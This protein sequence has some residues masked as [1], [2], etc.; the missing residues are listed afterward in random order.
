MTRHR[1][2]VRQA[3][4]AP[5]CMSS[6]SQDSATGTALVGRGD[7]YLIDHLCSG[8]GLPCPRVGRN[9]ARKQLFRAVPMFTEVY[10]SMNY[11][12]R[13]KRPLSKWPI[14]HE[15]SQNSRPLHPPKITH[16]RSSGMGRCGRTA[17][18]RVF[19]CFLFCFVFNC[20]DST[21]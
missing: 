16:R 21:V 18:F 1:C 10:R 2:L 13:E 15:T 20:H 6:S 11:L 19:T 7:V 14:A 5:R 12:M 3:N 4:R 9:P 8:E 17:C